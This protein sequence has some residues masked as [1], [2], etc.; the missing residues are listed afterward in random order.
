[1][2]VFDDLPEKIVVVAVLRQVT[3]SAGFQHL[4]DIP[5]VFEG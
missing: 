5:F 2:P 3:F 1:M 4:I